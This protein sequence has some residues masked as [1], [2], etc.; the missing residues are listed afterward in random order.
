MICPNCSERML[1]VN[2]Y[3][4]PDTNQTARKY[5]C[6]CG[7]ITYTL[8]TDT[9]KNGHMLEALSILSKRNENRR[10]NQNG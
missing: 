10:K 2:S 8:E 1:C 5:K 6:E 4:D 3:N 9:A 7:K